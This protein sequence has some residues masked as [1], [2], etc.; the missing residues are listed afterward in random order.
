M[1]ELKTPLKTIR[2]YCLTYC[3]LGSAPEVRLC[4]S[5]ECPLYEMRIG[6]GSEKARLTP[7]QAIHRM[8][9][10][11]SDG[12]YGVKACP[13]D[14]CDLYRYRTGRRPRKPSEAQKTELQALSAP[15]TSEKVSRPHP[16][17]ETA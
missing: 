11:C 6:K 17:E 4:T 2:G 13:H 1:P 14:D 8:C 7:L 15:P 16:E 3:M 9:A 5:P 12:V 10:D